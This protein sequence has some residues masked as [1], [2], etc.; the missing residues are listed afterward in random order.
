MTFGLA[1]KLRAGASFPPRRRRLVIAAL[2]MALLAAIWA[3][4]EVS[5]F[6]Q[7]IT[8]ITALR[9][10][11][12]RLGL[13]GPLV[14][15]GLMAANVVFSPLPS[16]PIVIAAGAAY[17]SLW[18][19]IYVLAGA[20][21]GSLI[22][23]FIARLLGG[24][25]VQR[26]LGRNPAL[27]ML[28]DQTTLMGIVFV[29]RLVP[30]MSF[31]PISYG[32]GLTPLSWWRFALANLAG[33]VPMNFILV[34]FGSNAIGAT[35]LSILVTLAAIGGVVLITVLLAIHLRRRGIGPPDPTPDSSAER[36]DPRRHRQP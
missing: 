14:V 6:A 17:G 31:D 30:F 26:W 5:D 3:L 22:A 1:A 27:R 33:L 2:T 18:G 7:Y 16:A 20:E 25:V 24:D 8:D 23:F 28:G 13:W 32:A 36:A 34:H 35:P 19:T 29:S 12:E 11:I 10:Q 9:E 15:I 21:L 4:L